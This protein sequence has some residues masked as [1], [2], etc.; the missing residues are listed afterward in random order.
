MDE[1]LKK[2]AEGRRYAVALGSLEYS[3]DLSKEL[4]AFSNKLETVFQKMQELRSHGNKDENAYQK[5]FK[6]LEEKFK[7]YQKAE[8][9]PGSSFA[10]NRHQ[11]VTQ[12]KHRKFTNGLDFLCFK[13]DWVFT[14]G[15]LFGSFP[16]LAAAKCPHGFNIS[17]MNKKYCI[18]YRW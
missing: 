7:W 8:A 11:I 3:G 4:M 9:R 10:N 6:I 15:C 1:C 12:E 17:W 18:R 5:Y 16:F 2:S 13:H 14:G